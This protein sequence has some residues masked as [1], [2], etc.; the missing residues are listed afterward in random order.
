MNNYFVE[1]A[2]GHSSPL[3][4]G[5]PS[6]WLG[7]RLHEPTCSWLNEEV[8]PYSSS[9]GTWATAAR[10]VVT[11]LEYCAAREVDWREAH[12]INLLAYRDAY[13]F[14]ISPK[15]GRP[16]KKSTVRTRMTFIVSFLNFVSKKWAIDRSDQVNIY[17]PKEA[18]NLFD[19]GEVSQ[20]YSERFLKSQSKDLLKI[21]PKA[22]QDDTVRIMRK[23]DLKKLIDWL[24]PRPSE[25][26]NNTDLGNKDRD[27]V[28]FA[29]GWAVGLR[30]NEMLNLK[31]NPFEVIVVGEDQLS[32]YYKIQV[33]GKGNKI[34]Q[35]DIP[36]WL[37]KDI[38]F[39]IQGS[40]KEALCARGR[41][42]REA[43]LLLNGRSARRFVGLPI[44]KSGLDLIMKRACEACGFIEEKVQEKSLS[45]VSRKRTAP[46]FSLHTL[47]HTYAVMTY[48]T[49]SISGFTEIEAW[50]YVQLQLGH[51]SP[52]TTIDFYLRH[53]TIW[54]SSQ[55][56]SSLK[57]V[58][59]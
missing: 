30:A 13:L 36:G 59:E 40:R 7:C 21:I 27:F 42:F 9:A 52:K 49:M 6:V 48:K 43:K 41:S 24:G 11:W 47:R 45:G 4:A 16:F 12:R 17:S 20:P 2:D 58:F 1:I 26:G 14:G 33:H 3:P 8:V 51:E 31:V 46:K 44:T 25:L 10:S 50:K 22:S 35:V 37:I 39:Y 28:L 54:S 18:S 29:L 55:T 53:V 32:A 15:T 5:Y 57:K 38:Q 19:D 56:S 34:R 23:E